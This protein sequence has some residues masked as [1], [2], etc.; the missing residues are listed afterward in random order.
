[1]QSAGKEM[2]HTRGDRGLQWFV[3]VALT[4]TEA[5]VPA[6]SSTAKRLKSHGGIIHTTW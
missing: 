5:D 1:M 2:R 3:F 4:E 6:L